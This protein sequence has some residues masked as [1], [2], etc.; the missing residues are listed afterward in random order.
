[1]AV[2]EKMAIGKAAGDFAA[3]RL[4]ADRARADG[5]VLG[6]EKDGI[7]VAQSPA[8]D[9]KELGSRHIFEAE[10]GGAHKHRGVIVS[11]HDGKRPRRV[12]QGDIVAY[13]SVDTE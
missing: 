5:R 7:L 10:I 6:V 1:M 3:G 4:Q 9:G 13:A 11:T 12:A 2:G 8:D